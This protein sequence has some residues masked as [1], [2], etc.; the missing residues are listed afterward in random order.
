MYA[1]KTKT[2]K[3]LLYDS[4]FWLFDFFF[5]SRG[6]CIATFTY[7]SDFWRLSQGPGISHLSLRPLQSPTSR[8][9][10]RSC[11][12]VVVHVVAVRWRPHTLNPLKNISKV[13][14]VSVDVKTFCC[15]MVLILPILSH[16]GDW[17]H[18]LELLQFF[19]AGFSD[20]QR[21]HAKPLFFFTALK[22]DCFVFLSMLMRIWRSPISV[23]LM[24]DWMYLIYTI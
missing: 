9:L 18:V 6:S 3:D 5:A 1:N 24:M 7:V 12:H 13:K 19:Y 15:R 16:M 23:D 21:D 17:D 11:L 20:I 4:I 2:T 22:I 8:K 10:D 14:V